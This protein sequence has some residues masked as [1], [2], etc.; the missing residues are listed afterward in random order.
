MPR[1]KEFWEQIDGPVITTIKLLG[2][3]F[4]TWWAAIQVLFNA[5]KVYFS[6]LWKVWSTYLKVAKKAFEIAV[7]VVKTWWTG[8]KAVIDVVVAAVKL[9]IDG[10]KLYIKTAITLV[11]GYFSAVWTVFQAVLETV[12]TVIETAIGVVVTVF[13]GVRDTVKGIIN[14]MLGFWEGLANGII[15]V[16]NK[17]IGAWNSLR[18]EIPKFKV[19]GKSF[20]PWGFGTPQIGTLAKAS[21]PRLAEGGIVTKPTLA[22]IGE[23]GPEAVVPLSQYQPGMGP[24]GQQ[25]V[26][27]IVDVRTNNR[28]VTAK[29]NALNATVRNRNSRGLH[30]QRGLF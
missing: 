21:I 24:G 20:G 17:I 8:V 10:V 6:V 12:K 4:K 26:Q 27:V 30:K 29:V 25:P 15:G 18:F 2:T 11:K 19:F 13:E 7:T 5:A 22:L 3:V 28:M 1:F 14:T 23:A 16:I 9:Y